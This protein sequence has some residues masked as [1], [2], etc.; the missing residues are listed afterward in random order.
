MVEACG[1]IQLYGSSSVFDPLTNTMTDPP[2]GTVIKGAFHPLGSGCVECIGREG[3]KEAG[4][5]TAPLTTHG[6]TLVRHSR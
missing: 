5:G 2:V 1:G 6:I 4:Q 3:H